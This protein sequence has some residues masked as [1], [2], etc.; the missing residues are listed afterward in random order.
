MAAKAG[1]KKSRSRK[2]TR[3]LAKSEATR[4]RVFDAAARVLMD[5]GYAATRL[6][7]IAELADLQAGSL[8]Y[9]FDSKE[10]LVE[11]VLRYGVQFTHTHVREAVDKLPDE[12]G[13]GK[14]LEA[15]VVAYLEAMLDL[16]DLAPAHFRTFNQI[17]SSMQERL[18]PTRRSFGRFWEELMDSAIEAS[19]IRTDID[20]YILRLFVTNTLE[21]IPEWPLRTRRASDELASTMRTL[22]F[23]G[24]GTSA[25]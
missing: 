3:S 14:R 7:D 6:G 11:E 13:P 2:P 10:E 17:P 12:A 21:R 5:K 25:R 22:I 20:P 19:E 16:G 24:I 23:D 4:R 18:R 15:A 9:Y 1:S 8:Y